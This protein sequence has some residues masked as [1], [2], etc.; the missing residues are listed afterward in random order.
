MGN[1]PILLPIEKSDLNTESNDLTSLKNRFS[2]QLLFRSNFYDLITGSLLVMEKTDNRWFYEEILHYSGRTHDVNFLPVLKRTAAD[3][4]LGES[5]QQKASELTEII[6]EKAGH[7]N[8]LIQPASVNNEDSRAEN[9]RKILSGARYPQTTEILRLLRDKS[10]ELKQLALCLIGKFK[11]TDMIQEVCECLNIPDLEADAFSVLK[12]FGGEAVKDINR[13]YLTSSG[14]TNVSKAI[15]KLYSLVCP[16]DNMSFLIERLS[17]NSRQ[18]KEIALKALLRCGYNPDEEEKIRLRRLIYDT[19]GILAWLVSAKVSLSDKSKNGLSALIEKEYNRW[20]MF[21]LDLLILT[22]GKSITPISKRDRKSDEISRQIPELADIFYSDI[23]SKKQSISDTVAD[24]KRLLKLQ[25]YFPCSVPQYQTLLEDIINCDY[26]V[27]N[28][29]TKACAVRNLTPIE[30]QH[31]WDS[32]VALLFS[33]EWILKEEAARLIAVSDKKIYSSVSERV[34]DN[35]R[36]KLEKVISGEADSE[37][38]IYEKVRFL[39]SF[40]SGIC[41]EELIFLA[42]RTNYIKNINTDFLRQV[43]ESVIW[44]VTPE[45]QISKVYVIHSKMN[46][47]DFYNELKSSDSSCYVL[48]LNTVELFRFHYPESSFGIF[49]YLDEVED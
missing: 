2:G 48:Q 36:V 29:W 38:L 14:N 47:V 26:N 20:K 21:V 46:G 30:N 11:I 45:K 43:E 25:R 18:I 15:L 8:N 49:K 3:R 24:K 16:K 4:R 42:E 35:D 10:P 27:V 32:M 19:F 17:T 44:I 28:I 6:E 41:E 33:P 1:K 22:Y 5:L 40:L 37:D 12:G 31:A 7:R 23:N 9:A 13:C 34:P 39:T